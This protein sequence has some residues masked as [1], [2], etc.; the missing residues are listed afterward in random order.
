M[1]TLLN[2]INGRKDFPIFEATDKNIAQWVRE[3]LE[4]FDL[5]EAHSCKVFL[6]PIDKT[7]EI[8]GDED[9]VIFKIID[10]K[11]IVI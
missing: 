7:I 1:K 3:N 8:S 9:L 6:H 2:E 5:N 10:V 4:L 11:I